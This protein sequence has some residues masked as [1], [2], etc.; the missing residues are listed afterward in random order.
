MSTTLGPIHYWL[1]NKIG[2]QEELT[3]AIAQEAEEKG[4]IPDASQYTKELPPLESVIDTAN[5]HG[6]LQS[7]IADAETRYASLLDALFSHP[8]EV[9]GIAFTF[10][11]QHA[12]PDHAAAEDLYQHFDSFFLNGMP[13][14]RVNEVTE[15]SAE[16][17]SWQMNQDIHAGYFPQGTEAYYRIRKAVM[18]GMLKGTAYHVRMPD[19][20][21]YTILK[22]N[23]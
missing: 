2:N 21:H 17:L 13:C 4:W 19:L 11:Q 23:A 18:D 5:I 15:Q 14:E 6:W 9:R 10:G 8:E 3:A 7:Q 22:D 20:Y 16:C 1:Y 12:A